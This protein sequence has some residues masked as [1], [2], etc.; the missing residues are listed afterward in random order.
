MNEYFIRL[1]F[2]LLFVYGVNK[3]ENTIVFVFI[4]YY[5]LTLVKNINFWS[6]MYFLDTPFSS[7]SYNEKVYLT[8]NTKLEKSWS[9]GYHI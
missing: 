4:V 3:F 9:L 7:F 2:V 8:K 1:F 5:S 6:D